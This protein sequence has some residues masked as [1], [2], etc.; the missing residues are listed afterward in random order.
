MYTV[1]DRIAYARD[2]M[3]SCRYIVGGDECIVTL[4]KAVVG[5][6]AG[7]CGRRWSRVREASF[8]AAE[9]LVDIVVGAWG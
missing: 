1:L 8:G 3:G 4:R 2:A 5:D 9:V 6:V 7:R